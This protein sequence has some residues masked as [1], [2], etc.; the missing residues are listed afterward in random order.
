MK[1][2]FF[3]LLLILSIGALQAQTFS[4]WIAD[5]N[6]PTLKVRYKQTK[7]AQG[8]NFITMEIYNSVYCSMYVTASFCNADAKDKN[9]WQL[10][11]I[12][13]NTSVIR[14]FKILNSCVNGFWWWYKNYKTGVLID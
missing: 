2:I 14:H 12:K 4:G 6:H 9:G 5:A 13:R 8:Y 1:K 10:V 7:N 3:S 11:T